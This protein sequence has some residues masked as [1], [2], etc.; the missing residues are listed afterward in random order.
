[1]FS[2]YFARCVFPHG[3]LISMHAMYRRDR[4]CHLISERQRIPGPRSVSVIAKATTQAENPPPLP[5]FCSPVF[6]FTH[7]FFRLFGRSPV[8]LFSFQ[9]VMFTCSDACSFT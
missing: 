7:L 4:N 3:F 5:L 9:L 2:A 6:L 8:L 1:M